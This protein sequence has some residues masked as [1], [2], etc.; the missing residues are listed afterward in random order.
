VQLCLAF[1]E[2]RLIKPAARH[3]CFLGF[4][5]HSREWTPDA[6]MH[7]F[8]AAL[9]AAQCSCGIAA[10]SSLAGLGLDAQVLPLWHMSSSHANVILPFGT[11]AA[12]ACSMPFSTTS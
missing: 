9:C 1:A 6:S 3:W 10:I 8:G 5:F 4:N 11:A 12:A 2:Q 7:I